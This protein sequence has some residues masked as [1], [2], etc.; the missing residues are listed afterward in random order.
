MN[1]APV[2]KE[3]SSEARKATTDAISSGSAALAMGGLMVMGVGGRVAWVDCSIVPSLA[4]LISSVSDSAS[5]N[6]ELKAILALDV[7]VPARFKR[8]NNV[9][10]AQDVIT[11]SPNRRISLLKFELNNLTLL[12]SLLIV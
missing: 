3:A 11:K 12:V 1:A 2:K 9:T 8:M 6:S 5:L 4:E 10:S 7:V